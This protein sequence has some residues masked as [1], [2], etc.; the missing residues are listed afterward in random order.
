MAAGIREGN[1]ESKHSKGIR[2]H[3]QGFLQPGLRSCAASLPPHT[4]LMT[5]HW[6]QQ[7]SGEGNYAPPLVGEEQGSITEEQV[8]EDSAKAIFGNTIG[9]RLRE[10]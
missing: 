9:H 8:R 5:S 3:L 10:R 1:P 2:I 6:V 7:E 4:V